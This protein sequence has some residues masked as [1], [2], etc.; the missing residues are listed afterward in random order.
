LNVRNAEGQALKFVV[1]QLE[2]CRRSRDSGCADLHAVREIEKPSLKTSIPA[3]RLMKTATPYVVIEVSIDGGNKI[4]T[5]GTTDLVTLNKATRCKEVRII[6]SHPF[7]ERGHAGHRSQLE[8]HKISKVHGRETREQ[9]SQRV[10]VTEMK[11]IVEC[12]RSVRWF[13]RQSHTVMLGFARAKPVYI[14]A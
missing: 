8:R 2:Q 11:R 12:V 6:G 5:E 10:W 3:E 13:H 7:M 9:A 14:L 4:G 1:H